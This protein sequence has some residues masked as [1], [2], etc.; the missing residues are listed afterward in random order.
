MECKPIFEMLVWDNCKNNCRFCF[1]RD[2]PRIFNAIQKAQICNKVIEFLDSDQ[3]ING[4]HVLI[5]GGEIFDTPS[6]EILL[7]NF[8]NKIIKYLNH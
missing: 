5:V 3:F 2:N 8:F 4:S 6:D 1:Q 7:N